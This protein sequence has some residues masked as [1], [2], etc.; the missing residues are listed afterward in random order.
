MSV[1][2]GGRMQV[3]EIFVCKLAADK[4]AYSAAVDSE[5][6]IHGLALALQ[7]YGGSMPRQPSSAY[8]QRP[9][10]G[11]P[12][13]GLFGELVGRVFGGLFGGLVGG[14]VGGPVS[15]LFSGRAGGLFSGRASGRAG[16][17][18]G[19]PASGLFSVG[20]LLVFEGL[21]R[22]SDTQVGL[23]GLRGVP[24]LWAAAG[25]GLPNMVGSRGGGGCRKRKRGL[26]GCR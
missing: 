7:G 14:V 8:M 23:N 17:F 20:A 9:G 12:I 3:G 6:G 21:C 19:G 25:S 13:S 24:H 5:R 22:S 16:G 15:G 4:H 1:G 10:V 2:V 18:A 26:G 11:G